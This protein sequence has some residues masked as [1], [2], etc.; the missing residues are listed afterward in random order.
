ML[1]HKLTQQDIDKM[2]KLAEGQA[3]KCL[4]IKDI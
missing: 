1:R 4:N 3:L 2:K